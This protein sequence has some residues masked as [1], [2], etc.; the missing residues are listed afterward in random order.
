MPLI[1][2]TTEWEQSDFYAGIFKGKLYSTIPQA[3]IV[4]NVSSLPYNNLNY[5]SFVIRHTYPYYPKGSIHLICVNT[6]SSNINRI[7]VVKADEHYFIGTDDGKFSLI[8]HNKPIE[9]VAINSTEADELDTYVDLAKALVSGADFRSLGEPTSKINVMVPISASVTQNVIL[10][11]VIYNDTYGNAI[12]NIT[13]EMFM[14]KFDGI[15]FRIRIP[16]NINHITAISDKYNMLSDGSL[17]ARFNNVGLLE[18]A[19]NNSNVKD[20]FNLEEGAEVRVEA[21]FVRPGKLL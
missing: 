15:D 3:Q 10:G 8:F 21:V 14:K 17:L 4:D 13:K 12:T 5:V 2:L 18:I 16:G 1:T 7:M 20:L 19:M 9:C 6:E 11:R